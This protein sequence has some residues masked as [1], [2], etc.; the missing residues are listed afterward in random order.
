M[1]RAVQQEAGRAL[2][3]SMS[4]SVGAIVLLIPAVFLAVK[5]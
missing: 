1:M 3:E 4:I 2:V 5:D